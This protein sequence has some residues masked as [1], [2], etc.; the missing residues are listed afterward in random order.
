MTIRG[1]VVCGQIKT[2]NNKR[3]VAGKGRDKKK[4]TLCIYN[5]LHEDSHA[6]VNFHLFSLAEFSNQPMKVNFTG[7][8]SGRYQL[9]KPP[10]Y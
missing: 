6:L 4:S 3:Q 9:I 2:G 8:W 10:D 1:V 5:L 7:D